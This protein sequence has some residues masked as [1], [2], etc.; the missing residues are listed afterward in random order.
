MTRPLNAGDLY[1][2]L[3]D[4]GSIKAAAARL[5]MSDRTIT[6]RH[7]ADPSIHD[8]VTRGLA[9]HRELTYPH[10]KDGGY[11]QGCRCAACR[12]AHATATRARRAERST[13]LKDVEHGRDNTYKNWGCRCDRCT[14]AHSAALKQRRTA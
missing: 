10:G 11:T 4:L 5:G 6:R 13:H 8:A 3:V 14:A 12:A 9:K 1:D 2:A 7:K